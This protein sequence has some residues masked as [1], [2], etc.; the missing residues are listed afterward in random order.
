MGAL[1]TEDSALQPPGK[2]DSGHRESIPAEF[3]PGPVVLSGDAT[4]EPCQE[5]DPWWYRR[6][7]RQLLARW[8]HFY[9]YTPVRTSVPISIF[10]GILVGGGRG[11]LADRASLGLSPATPDWSH[12][13]PACQCASL[14]ASEA[15]TLI[16]CERPC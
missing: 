3:P 5:E 2:L 10:L 4:P 7:Y 1:L 16:F 14:G 9:G 13:W 6:Q 11:R 12:E 15:F 8:G